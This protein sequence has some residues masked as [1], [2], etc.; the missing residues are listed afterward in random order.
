MC[1]IA[2]KSQYRNGDEF[3]DKESYTCTYIIYNSYN[4]LCRLKVKLSNCYHQICLLQNDVQQPNNKMQSTHNSNTIAYKIPIRANNA[5]T[6]NFVM[7]QETC[8]I[9]LT[10]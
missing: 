3:T 8:N 7:L 4:N 2:I 6:S 5:K 1:V 10:N 9:T